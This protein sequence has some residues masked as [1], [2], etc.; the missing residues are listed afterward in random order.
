M[1]RSWDVVRVNTGAARLFA[2]LS[3]PEP[4]PD[5]ANVLRLMLEPGPVRARPWR[6]GTRSRRRCSSA[7]AAKRSAG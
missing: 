3:A 7:P 5:P 1:D 4:V 6:T 2:G